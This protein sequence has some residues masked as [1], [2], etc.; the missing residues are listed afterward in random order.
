MEDNKL[1]RVV[2]VDNDVFERLA[3][4]ADRYEMLTDAL[5]ECSSLS[6]S[7]D[8]LTF[9]TGVLDIVLKVLEP[10][11]YKQRLAQLKAEKE[12]KA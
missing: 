9:D 2:I 3:Q 7:R 6:Y 8:S 4:I 11:A 12:K 10:R 1:E 5:L